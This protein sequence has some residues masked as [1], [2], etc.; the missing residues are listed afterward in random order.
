MRERILSATCAIVF[1]S[2]VISA[3]QPSRGNGSIEIFSPSELIKFSLFLTSQGNLTYT[4]HYNGRQVIEPSSLGITIDQ[5][6]LGAG[7]EI[8][9]P[10]FSLVNETYPSNGVH[11]LAANHYRSAIVQVRHIKTRT[12]YQLEVRAFNNGLAF[13]YLLPKKGSSLVSGE[14]SSWKIPKGSTVWFQDNVFYYEG[15]YNATPLSKLGAKRIG[16]PLTYQTTDSIY[17]SITEAA[18]YNYSGMSLQSDNKGVLHAAFVNDPKGWTIMDTVVSPWRAAIITKDL[19]GL[20]NAD[21]IQ[22]LNPAP[23]SIFHHAGWIKPGRAVW[24]YFEHENV[25]TM[26]LERTYIDKAALL[27]FEYNMVDAGW[28]SS[29]P[30]AMDSL[31]AL[32]DYAQQKKVGIWVWKSYASLKESTFRRT[33]FAALRKIG[34]AGV[35]IDFIDEEG[36]SQVKFY[37][38][39]LKDAALAHLMI[40][41][42]GA[43]KPTG[44]NRTYPN[45][46]TREAIYGQEWTTYTPQGP[47]NN[48]IIPFTRFIA[49]PADYTPG[50]F[51]SKRAYGTSWAHQLALQIIFNSVLS[52]WPSDPDLYLSSAALPLIKSIPT[53]WDETIVLTHSRI[54]ELAA[55]ARR[56]G[57]DWY[58]GIINAGDEKRIVLPLDF[59]GAG[60]FAAQVIQDDLTNSDHLLHMQSAYSASDSILVVMKPAGGFAA[61]FIKTNIEVPAITIKPQGGY[62]YAPA[63]VTISANPNGEIRYTMDGTEPTMN[64][65]LY[66]RPITITNPGIIR[67]RVFRNAQPLAAIGVAQFLLAPA[68]KL[69]S[70]GGI[71]INSKW[72]FVSGG[73]KNG[74]IHYTLDGSEPSN[75]APLFKDSILLT[76]TATLK[77]KI[78]FPSGLASTTVTTN[79]IKATPTPAITGRTTVSGL[80]AS[81]Y[82]GKWTMMPDFT[83]LSPKKKELV[84]LPDLNL[85]KTRKEFYAVQF[86][87]YINIPAGGVYTF[88]IVSDD[89]AQLLMDGQQLVDNDGCHGD[90]EKSGEKALAAGMHSFTINYFQNGSGQSLKVYIKGPGTEKKLIPASMFFY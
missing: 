70:P 79:F 47:L 90:L 6:N 81:Y 72:L 78:F 65:T 84:T 42:H 21:I 87:G 62:L 26:D 58:L 50:V 3:Q 83:K 12:N 59:L 32:V 15:L 29:W 34:V 89:G 35:K 33:F 49:G 67:A 23:D 2:Q 71:F 68:P 85:L 45:E 14:A 19:N 36:I 22:N 31:K 11:A 40:N 27:G 73:Q 18:L 28:E 63:L 13:R 53:T 38:N 82:E 60:N 25:T 69:S 57:N 1:F 77:A 66:E 48:C 86:S 8:A 39:T 52:C 54:G 75:T 88:Y 74:D 44:I 43:N 10:I 80:S 46:L 51:D 16:P 41:F 24:S 30:D 61:S 56:K 7:V 37:E 20:V 17:V 5:K 76:G 9:S 4:V 64:A 55:F